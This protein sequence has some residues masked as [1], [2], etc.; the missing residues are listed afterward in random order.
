[1]KD[2]AHG[3]ALVIDILRESF[4]WIATFLISTFAAVAQYA[5]KL[6]NGIRASWRGFF[7]DLVICSFAGMLMH[8]M[9]EWQGVDGPARSFLVAI[10]AHMGA[11]AMLQFEAIR[12]R[13]LGVP[14]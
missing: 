5:S 8:L 7:L 12:D 2:N 11:R 4:P 3:L 1:M 10:T 14:K 6:R 9:C 13:F